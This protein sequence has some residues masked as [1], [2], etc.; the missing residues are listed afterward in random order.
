VGQPTFNPTQTHLT[1]GLSE[2]S[3]IQPAFV[4]QNFSQPNPARLCGEHGLVHGMKF[5]LTSLVLLG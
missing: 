3:S 1:C 5:I 2:S 4:K